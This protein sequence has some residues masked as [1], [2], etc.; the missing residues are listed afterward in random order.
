MPIMY[1]NIFQG[2]MS[3]FSFTKPN[4]ETLAEHLNPAESARLNANKRYWDFHE[5][6]H[7]QEIPNDGS[8]PQ[9]T[10]NWCRRFVTKWTAAEFGEGFNIKFKKEVEKQVL[11]FV[12]EVWEDNNYEV[13]IQDL[14]Q[15]K[16]VTGDGFIHIYFEH[17][18]VWVNKKGGND[19]ELELIDNPEFYDPFEMFPKGRIRLFSIPSSICFPTYKTGYSRIMES[20]T[21]MFP[22]KEELPLALKGE[23]TRYKIVKYIY[24]PDRIEYWEGKNL[25]STEENIYGIIPIVHFRNL[26]SSGSHFGVSDLVDIVPLNVEINLKNSDASE[27]IDYHS[28]PVTCVFGAKISQLER[29]ANKVWGGLPKDGKVENLEMKSDMSFATNYKD[30]IKADMFEIASM[31]EVAISG[32]IERSNV[33]GAALHTAFMPLTDVVKM[34]RACSKEGLILV[35]RIILKVALV[36]ELIEGIKEIKPRDLYTIDIDFGDILPKDA[37]IE[38]QQI[39][40]ERTLGFESRTGAMRRLKKDNIEELKTEIDAERKENPAMSGIKPVVLTPGQRLV[41]PDTGEVIAENP[42]PVI[43]QTPTE[44]DSTVDE[45]EGKIVG[46]NKKKK[47]IKVN[48]GMDNKNPGKTK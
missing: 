35:N 9:V 14:S 26:V 10:E 38:L 28:Q 42:A 21:I 43:P 37:L 20:C 44:S 25:I 12:N 2:L 46:E 8:K 31:P 13:L 23:P 45:P 47:P 33:S 29:G 41:N 4:F 11:P 48:P 36:E 40:K 32:N 6:L 17:P 39:E 27:I 3:Q 1:N 16:N 19:G 30:G 22:I 18:Q 5:G 34:K 7:W 15:N 24:Y